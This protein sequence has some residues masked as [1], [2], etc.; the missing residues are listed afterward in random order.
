MRKLFEYLPQNSAAYVILH[1]MY[2]QSRG[3]RPVVTLGNERNPRKALQQ[4]EKELSAGVVTIRPTKPCTA[5]TIMEVMKRLGLRGLT[6]DE[7]K[8]MFNANRGSDTLNIDWFDRDPRNFEN[9]ASAAF[10]R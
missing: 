8:K 2:R 5:C 7:A 1:A 3:R 10:A 6:V 4:A 9:C